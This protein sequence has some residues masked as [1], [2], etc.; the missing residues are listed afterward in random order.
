MD[1]LNATLVMVSAAIGQIVAIDYRNNDMRKSHPLNSIS[2]LDWL[3][4]IGGIGSFERFDRAEPAATRTLAASDHEGCSAA[5]PTVM[6]IGAAGFFAHR[7][8]RVR[9]DGVLGFIE[10]RKAI[11]RGKV[12]SQPFRQAR[13]LRLVEMAWLDRR[14]IDNWEDRQR[15]V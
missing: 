2:E 10:D 5:G 11:S 9:I 7:V 14:F 8:K 6:N 1:C 13:P 4:W 12:N 15:H 3:G